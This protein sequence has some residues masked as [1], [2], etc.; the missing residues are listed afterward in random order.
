MVLY[1]SAARYFWSYFA[2]FFLE[3]EMFQKNV[4][5]E[6]KKQILFSITFSKS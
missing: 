4:V 3:C 2:Q 5:E 1:L 6:M